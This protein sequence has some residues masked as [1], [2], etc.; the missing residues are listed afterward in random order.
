LSNSAVI[1]KEKLTAYQRWELHTFEEPQGQA[2]THP[3]SPA[4]AADDEAAKIRNVHQLAYES[5]RAD[6]LREATAK[7]SIDAQNFAAMVESVRRQ[8]I[9]LNHVLADE[10]LGV[11]LSIAQQMV[12]QSLEANAGGVIAV[13]QEALSRVIQPA[14]Q[15]TITLNPADA[16]LVQ[17]QL[18][19]T[20][21]A[22]HWRIVEDPNTMR[23]G[24]LLHTLASELDA[25]VETRWRR[26]TAALGQDTPWLK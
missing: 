20:L 15:A 13:V 14:A 2:Q 23:G 9:D 11:A 3:R 5:G 21:A 7:T 10:L 4:R 16:A 1:P 12:R 6:G 17:S 26:I 19:E 24:C 22:G 18:G 25:T 8:S